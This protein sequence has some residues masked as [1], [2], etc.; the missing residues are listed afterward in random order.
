MGWLIDQPGV[1]VE[2]TDS[3]NTEC[4]LLIFTPGSNDPIVFTVAQQQEWT[5]DLRETIAARIEAA[6]HY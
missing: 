5:D 6:N 4:D 2:N 1:R 3:T